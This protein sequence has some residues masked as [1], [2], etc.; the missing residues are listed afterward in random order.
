[1]LLSAVQDRA[2][3]RRLILILYITGLGQLDVKVPMSSKYFLINQNYTIAGT[4][5]NIGLVKIL[6]S[7]IVLCGFLVLQLQTVKG[8]GTACLGTGQDTG[9]HVELR[10]YNNI[11]QNTG[12]PAQVTRNNGASLSSL[13]CSPPRK[14]CFKAHSFPA[15]HQ[16]R[17]EVQLAKAI[18]SENIFLHLLHCFSELGET[19]QT[20]HML[21]LKIIQY[22]M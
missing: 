15:T 19:N 21:W 5:C 14:E 6:H 2:K 7:Q 3:T 1:M 4:S 16:M 18:C 13:T 9:Q 20:K 22:S 11:R 8:A 17:M 10:D 12:T